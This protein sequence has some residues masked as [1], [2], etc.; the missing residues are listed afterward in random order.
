MIVVRDLYL[1]A[2]LMKD[3]NITSPEIRERLV[4]L[5][6]A[7]GPWEILESG[8]RR[9]YDLI[10][11]NGEKICFDGADHCCAGDELTG[12]A[13]DCRRA[14]VSREILESSKLAGRWLKTQIT[15]WQL[16][17]A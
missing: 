7:V 13:G 14:T 17:R 3:R 4:N 10:F 15:E 1:V 2:L 16:D 8:S 12:L 9:A 6:D 5:A 11:S